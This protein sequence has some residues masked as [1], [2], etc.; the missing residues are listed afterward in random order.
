MKLK[1]C[2]LDN[3]KGKKKRLENKLPEIL[4][5]REVKKKADS[6]QMKK[7]MKIE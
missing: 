1:G 4:K 6:S 7:K 5:N 2:M 3:A